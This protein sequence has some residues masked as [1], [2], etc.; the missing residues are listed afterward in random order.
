[1]AKTGGLTTRG[2]RAVNPRR[3]ALAAVLACCVTLA[4]C[5]GGFIYNRLDFIIPFYFGQRVTLDEPQEAQLKAA[6]RGFTSWHRSSQLKRYSNFLR[7]LARDA[8]R[9]TTREELQANA[10]TMESFWDDLIV[11]VAPQGSRLLLSLSEEQVDELLESFEE[12]DADDYEEYCEPSPR[13]LMER[14]VKGLT[15]AVK[16]WSRTLTDEQKA[17]IEGTAH[18]MELLGC[19]SLESRAQWRA[20][21]RKTLDA[22]DTGAASERLRALMVEPQEVWTDEYRRGFKANRAAILDML[23][24]LDTT[25]SPK[26]RQAIAT[27][28]EEIADDLDELAAG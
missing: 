10:E 4:A 17:V 19:A 3:A 21:I 8:H 9:P 27:R 20:E 12:D 18:R 24:H 22:R 11:E 2:V 7:S 13:K 6:V 1:M 14:R 16:Q 26:Q 23:A 28:L 15:R 5:T 25:W